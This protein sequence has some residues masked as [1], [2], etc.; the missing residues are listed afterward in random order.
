MKKIGIND[1]FCE[2]GSYKELIEKYGLN[3]ENI[4]KTI[5]KIWKEMV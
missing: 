2:S 1:V 3:G 4:A 5:K